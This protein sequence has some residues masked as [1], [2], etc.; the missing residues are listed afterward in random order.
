MIWAIMPVSL[1]SCFPVRRFLFTAVAVFS[2]LIPQGDGNIIKAKHHASDPTKR[3]EALMAQAQVK[4]KEAAKVDLE[5]APKASLFRLKIELLEKGS[6]TRL[7]ARTDNLW[8]QIRCYSPHEGEN[9]M[10]AHHYQDHSFVIL[11]GTARFY[12]PLG[13][14]WNLGRNEGIML[15]SGAYY[16]FENGGDDPLVVMRI[17]SITRDVGDIN[18]RLGVKGEQIEPHSAENKRPEHTVIKEGAFYE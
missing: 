14:V 6:K 18:K 7:L 17:A 16:C 10:H 2:Q 1:A 3:R 13:E 11:Q 5:G 15:P 8:M 4:E 9:A 12:G